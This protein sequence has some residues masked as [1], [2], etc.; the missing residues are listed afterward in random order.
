M[1]F[2][3]IIVSYFSA[4]IVI[5]LVDRL[6]QLNGFR[7][8]VIVKAN[9]ESDFIILN[10]YFRDSSCVII[11]DL[12]DN[13]GF[14][15][16]CNLAVEASSGNQLVFINPDIDVE[17]HCLNNFLSFC[18]SRHSFIISPEIFDPANG[19]E[20]FFTATPSIRKVLSDLFF[21]SVIPKVFQGNNFQFIDNRSVFLSGCFFVVS[22]F[23]FDQVGGFDENFFLYYEETDLQYRMKNCPRVI[24]RDYRVV[25]NQGGA[26][27]D[28]Y[29]AL[30]AS[31]Q[32]HA[33]Y[34]LKHFGRA[35]AFL[36]FLLFSLLTAQRILLN[37]LRFRISSVRIWF[38]QYVSFF[39]LFFIILLGW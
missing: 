25:H 36:Y 33:K 10:D 28:K 17:I 15:Q 26:T 27:V 19:Q 37:F 16:G 20:Y 11:C 31:G 2:S 13:V 7:Y 29:R 9:C 24:Y 34:V 6:L 39:R 30:V 12:F 5:P 22:R 1:E 8:E 21:I 18:K 3:F 38:V 4:R 35:L 23:D 14:G 32:S